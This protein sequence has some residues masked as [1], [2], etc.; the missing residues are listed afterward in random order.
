MGDGGGRGENEASR[1]GGTGSSDGV[2]DISLC[3]FKSPRAYL[4]VLKGGEAGDGQCGGDR[5]SG[6][7]AG[8]R[9]AGRCRCVAVP[10]KARSANGTKDQIALCTSSPVFSLDYFVCCGD[11]DTATPAFGA[12]DCPPQPAHITAHATAYLPPAKNSR[13][14]A[15]VQ[16]EGLHFRCQDSWRLLCERL[17]VVVQSGD[18]RGGDIF[19]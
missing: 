5:V 16:G 8:E 6:F 14:S 9:E 2:A 4:Q 17:D 15:M 12:K 10:P 1:K 7:R 18:G 19:L 3:F 13:V 11:S